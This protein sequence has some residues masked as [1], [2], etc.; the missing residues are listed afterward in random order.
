MKNI[1]KK[2]NVAMHY[3]TFS[4]NIAVVVIF[5]LIGIVSGAICCF[6]S[7]FS[8][9][10]G[11]VFSVFTSLENNDFDYTFLRSFFT[12]SKYPVVIFILGFTAFGIFFIPVAV[13]LKGFF[14]SFSV[15]SVFKFVGA[16]AFLV[17]VSTFGIQILFSVPAIIIL[18]ALSFEFSKNFVVLFF[19]R[20]DTRT[21]KTDIRIFLIAFAC[22]IS[23]S[24]LFAFFD[25]IITPK[26]INKVS[27]LI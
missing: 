21:P 16:N 2:S 14:L 10:K 27:H 6:S 20:V 5:L 13:F 9:S 24:L 12:F 4:V 3:N 22:I 26:L 19:G 15:A 7:F 11:D 25:T 1:K 17:S 23:L 8:T 18:S